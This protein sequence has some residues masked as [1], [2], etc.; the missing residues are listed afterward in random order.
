MGI[1]NGALPERTLVRISPLPVLYAIG[2]SR[3]GVGVPTNMSTAAMGM[4]SSKLE[5]PSWELD[6]IEN[7]DI[8]GSV[9]T[10]YLIESFTQA[11]DTNKDGAFSLLE[12]YPYVN[13]K[14]IDEVRRQ[15]NT[16]QESDRKNWQD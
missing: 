1:E 6:S 16:T 12:A 10:H 2:S 5:E 9:F 8:D 3:D 13:S 7:S 15:K 4:Y 11:N 14:V